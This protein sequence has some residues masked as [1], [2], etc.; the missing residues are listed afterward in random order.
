MW[1]TNQQGQPRQQRPQ[2]IPSIP[3][4]GSMPSKTHAS[5]VGGRSLTQPVRCRLAAAGGCLRLGPKRSVKG[6]LV[7]FLAVGCGLND[8]SPKANRCS[9]GSRFLTALTVLTRLTVLTADRIDHIDLVDS[10]CQCGQ[11]TNMVILVNNVR[12]QYRQHRQWGQ[13]R[14]TPTRPP[15][16]DARSSNPGD[17]ALRQQV[18]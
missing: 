5:A 16:A 14:P 17:A 1:S 4:M 12:S 8:R 7:K 3:S 2:S 18:F 11:P 6:G 15:S 10:E 9:G 13:C